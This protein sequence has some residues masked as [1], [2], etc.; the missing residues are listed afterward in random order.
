MGDDSVH[1][2]LLLP[3]DTRARE[4]ANRVDML[5]DNFESHAQRFLD[6]KLA[7]KDR[8]ALAQE[9]RESI[10]IVQVRSRKSA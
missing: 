8:H 4:S 9:I 7:A 6:P 1:G 10:E 2:G 5:T 3:R